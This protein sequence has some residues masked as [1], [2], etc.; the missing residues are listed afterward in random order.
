MTGVVT[1]TPLA[2]QRG[3]HEEAS[4]TARV[5]RLV[6]CALPARDHVRPA[7]SAKLVVPLA[8]AAKL[9]FATAEPA[10][11]LRTSMAWISRPMSSPARTEM[12]PTSRA[13]VELK[14]DVVPAVVTAV[15]SCVQD[16]ASV[17]AV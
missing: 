8:C 1:S 12:S 6:I 17:G 5:R 10:M 9:G 7:A 11:P 16:P 3:T 4:S 13:A 14:M 15:P 2:P